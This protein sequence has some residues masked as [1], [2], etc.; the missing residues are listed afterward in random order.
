MTPA[1][2]IGV[3]IRTLRDARGMTQAELAK[4]AR[5]TQSHVSMLEAGARMRP[6][7]QTI[8]KLARALGVSVTE[9]LE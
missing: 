5:V 2:R 4:K 3:K 1:R 6:S 8:Q 9:L 7:I